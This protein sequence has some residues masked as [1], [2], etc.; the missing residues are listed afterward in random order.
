MNRA[1]PSHLSARANE[2]ASL[3]KSVVDNCFLHVSE[4]SG[5]RARIRI[6]WDPHRRGLGRLYM[7]VYI[8][9]VTLFVCT[10]RALSCACSGTARVTECDRREVAKRRNFCAAPSSRITSRHDLFSPDL[11]LPQVGYPVEY[12]RPRGE[13]IRFG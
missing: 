11:P 4:I 7:Y 9:A 12:N 13:E 3:L 1:G 2:R 8:G 6:P 10:L 5:G